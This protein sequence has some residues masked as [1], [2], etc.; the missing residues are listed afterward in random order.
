M[1]AD[2]DWVFFALFFVGQDSLLSL[3]L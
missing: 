3:A 1:P 2:G